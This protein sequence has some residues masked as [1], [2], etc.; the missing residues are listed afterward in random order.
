MGAGVGRERGEDRRM[1]KMLG[2]RT[3]MRGVQPKERKSQ[4]SI[5]HTSLGTH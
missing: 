2:L 5:A 4:T 1:L 3:Q